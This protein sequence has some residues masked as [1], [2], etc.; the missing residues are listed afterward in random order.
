MNDDI[1]TDLPQTLGTTIAA[2]DTINQRARR[3]RELSEGA[4]ERGFGAEAKV[5]SRQKDALYRLKTYVLTELYKKG[6]VESI[7]QHSINGINHYALRLVADNPPPSGLTERT[8]H[9]PLDQWEKY[10]DPIA[11]DDIDTTTDISSFDRSA[12]DAD[13][14]P[15]KLQ[16]ALT[17]L[18]DV[19]RSPNE[20]LTSPFVDTQYS[21]TNISWASLP[22]HVEIEDR[23]AAD[24]FDAAHRRERYQF[25]VGDEFE[26]RD[27]DSVEILDRYHIWSPSKFNSGPH[28]KPAYDIRR[29]GQLGYKIKQQP[30]I[31]EGLRLPDSQSSPPSVDGGAGE[32]LSNRPATQ[33]E[34]GDQIKIKHDDT[35]YWY[36][37]RDLYL[38][39]QLIELDIKA[40]DPDAQTYIEGEC[41]VDDLPGEIVA[42]RDT[43]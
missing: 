33:F 13:N 7:D 6:A 9:T 35:A 21:Y 16:T 37:V 18:A 8:F 17:Y 12:R 5:K 2:L 29:N 32:F 24:Y 39:D 42:V 40:V 43:E 19:Y 38:R 30:L 11:D 4:Y 28:P 3:Y 26:T 34:R 10:A 20:F 1:S 14:T 41:V 31:Q 36:Y 22:G 25:Q 15:L 27:G 23:V